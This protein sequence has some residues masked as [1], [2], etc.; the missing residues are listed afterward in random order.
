VNAARES[1]SPD[2]IP[3]VR[4]DQTIPFLAEGYPYGS[5]RF[6]RFGADA[7]RARLA[8]Q[9]VLFMRGA[10]AARFF[11][12]GD[13]FTRVGALPPTVVRSLQDIGSVQ[14]LS[15][16]DHR[17]RKGLF[18]DVLDAPQRAQMIDIFR[19]QWQ[20][21]LPAWQ[22]AGTI[23]LHDAV[24][25]V[26]TRTAIEWAGL[27]LAENE[28]TA[29][30]TE[31]LAMIDGAGAFGPRNWRGLALRH[32]TERWAQHVLSRVDPS[33]N[34][35]AGAVL[36]HRD[37]D[38]APLK[39]GTAAVELLNLLRPTVAVG[40]F[41]V[42]AALALHQHPTWQTRFRDGD[43]EHLRGFVQEVRRCAPF[44][45][46]V[47]GRAT[48]ALQWQ[49]NALPAGSWVLLDLFATNR[50]SE[51]WDAPST[52]RPERHTPRMAHL[53]AVVAQGAGDYADGHRCPGEPATVDL[54]AE[55]VRQMTRHMRYQVPRQNLGV[56]LA[57]FPT[58]PT[59]GFLMSH[60]RSV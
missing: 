42:F 38:G 41:V 18:L 16:A 31:F 45:P 24:A 10:S 17:A 52:F 39:L 9:Q 20:R 60:V 22:A 13:R 54:I 7:F 4:G 40:R 56:K 43:E 48:R 33:A 25:E 37:A 19:E 1:R 26:L 12:E 55:A 29:R 36:R 44:F 46:V 27:P 15:G 2:E 35:V 14:T 34:S 47:G 57:R 32:R 28:V 49:G 59:S 51:L 5:R 6:D 58:E 53:D 8:A 23:R 3:R 21:A 50:D 11:Y 30:T